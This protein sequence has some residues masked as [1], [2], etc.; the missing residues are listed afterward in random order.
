[1]ILVETVRNV[2]C[3]KIYFV[4]TGQGAG[5]ADYFYQYNV[6]NETKK[7]RIFFISLHSKNERKRHEITTI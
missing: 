2:I 3:E 5:V 4:P 7:E 6:P 1:V